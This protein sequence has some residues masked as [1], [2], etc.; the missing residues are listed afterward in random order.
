MVTWIDTQDTQ[1]YDTLGSCQSQKQN[2]INVTSYTTQEDDRIANKTLPMAPVS[3]YFYVEREYE[4]QVST[5]K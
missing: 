3:A 4:S 2:F 1:D 5:V